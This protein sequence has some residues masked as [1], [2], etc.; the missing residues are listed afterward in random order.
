M[1][2]K[3]LSEIDQEIRKAESGLKKLEQHDII[4]RCIDIVIDQVNYKLKNINYD[5]SYQD[6]LNDLAK[7]IILEMKRL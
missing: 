3:E 7:Q 1:F 2:E 6:N 4:S 5:K